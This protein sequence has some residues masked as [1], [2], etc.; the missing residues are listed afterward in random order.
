M[1]WE[2]GE[3]HTHAYTEREREREVVRI[4]PKRIVKGKKEKKR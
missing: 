3:I 2:G 4:E 1:R